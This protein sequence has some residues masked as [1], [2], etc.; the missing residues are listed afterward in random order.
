MNKTKKPRSPCVARA[1]GKV[2]NFWTLFSR[3]SHLPDFAGAD[4]HHIGS[5]D[6]PWSFQGGEYRNPRTCLLHSACAHRRGTWLLLD[7]L[8]LYTSLRRQRTQRSAPS[9]PPH[10]V[11]TFRSIYDRLRWGYVFRSRSTASCLPADCSVDSH[12]LCCRSNPRMQ[13]SF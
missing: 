1:P 12:R 13:T 4:R 8:W 6:A 10:E 11:D 2:K 7:D 5:M 9:A 3:P